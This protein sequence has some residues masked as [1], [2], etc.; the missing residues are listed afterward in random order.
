MMSQSGQGQSNN[1]NQN[2][3]QYDNR[4][5]DRNNPSLPNGPGNPLEN[6]Q[7]RPNS[8]GAK[9]M[10][11]GATEDKGT[12]N[13]DTSDNKTNVTV[14][15]V[16]KNDPEVTVSQSSNTLTPNDIA[17]KF[18]DFAGPTFADSAEF[19]KAMSMFE[20][21]AQQMQYNLDKN[22]DKSPPDTKLADQIRDLT[23]IVKDLAEAKP[24]ADN[25]L[26]FMKFEEIDKQLEA[27]REDI[28]NLKGELNINLQ[29]ELNK[30][31]E[32][33]SGMHKEH[34]EQLAKVM[35]FME[36]MQGGIQNDVGHNHEHNLSLKN[37]TR[38][39]QQIE[40]NGVNVTARQGDYDPTKEVKH[41]PVPSVDPDML[42]IAERRAALVGR[43][44]T[45]G[46]AK[47]V[48]P[49]G[50]NQSPICK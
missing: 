46:V 40:K 22:K 36:N 23:K 27:I 31:Q 24:A 45:P 32:F 37:N 1:Q 14:H 19:K 50:H 10:K 44:N 12:K 43:V 20:K 29:A 15:Q 17:K 13:I 30:I 11:A 42:T 2:Q 35:V 3:N 7:L 8:S 26:T 47:A 41:P 21:L 16:G 39:N 9:V 6:N 28:K 18:T 38:N 33:V 25:T 49:K 4:P 48:F 5:N 34:Q